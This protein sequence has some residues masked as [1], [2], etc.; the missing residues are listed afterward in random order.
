MK[1]I[2]FAIFILAV[3]SEITY[4]DYASNIIEEVNSDPTSTWVAGHNAHWDNFPIENIEGLM[5]AKE[6]PA[7]EKLPEKEIE[8]EVDLP[9]NFDSR[10][11]WPNCESIKEIRDQSDCGSCWAFGAV[12]AMSDRICITSG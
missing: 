8:V 11:N 5:G 10:I 2:V 4:N 12:E 7:W 3:S 9:T 6:E 1:L